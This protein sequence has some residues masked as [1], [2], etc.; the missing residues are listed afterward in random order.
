MKNESI[1]L[2]HGLARS[3]GSMKKLARSLDATGY[4]A[5]NMKYPSTKHSI[6]ELAEKVI[7]EAIAKCPEVSKINF[8]THSMGGILVRQYLEANT[9]KNMGRVVM[10]AP[11]NKGSEVVNTLSNMLGFKLINGP[12]GMELSTKESSTPN[13]LGLANF[14]LGVIAGNRSINLILSLILPSPNDGKVSVENTKLKGM[15]D[16]I[17]LPVT[18][19]FM[20]NNREVIFQVKYFLENGVFS[21]KI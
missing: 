20:M 15:L 7:P 19:T 17:V 4:F 14:E 6:K 8:V 13:T 9:I 5:M 21:K 10:L 16:H 1:I 3:S 2:L 11:P 18:H 12:A